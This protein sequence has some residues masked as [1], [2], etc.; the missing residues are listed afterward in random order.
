MPTSNNI[1]GA[2]QLYHATFGYSGKPAVAW[3]DGVPVKDSS[4]NPVALPTLEIL[5]EWCEPD[6]SFDGKVFDSHLLRFVVRATTLAEAA[7]IAHGIKYN[8][9][10]PDQFMGF[11]G[12]GSDNSGVTFP[13]SAGQ[14]LKSMTR[15]R[16][17]KYAREPAR[18]QNAAPVHRIEIP[19][20]AVVLVTA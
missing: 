12:A 20:L 11:D 10:A 7:S 1:I 13:F 19:Y 16:G 5:H 14:T 2:C 4:G 18:D 8:T 15:Q 3:F 6:F 9:G 17:E